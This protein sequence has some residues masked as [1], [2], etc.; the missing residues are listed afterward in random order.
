MVI[1]RLLLK[2][3]KYGKIGTDAM[4]A[5]SIEPISENSLLIHTATQIDASQLPVVIDYIEQIK[6]SFGDVILDIIPS[7]TT[8]L[9]V[10]RLTKISEET[11]IHKLK[12]LQKPLLNR[13][14][15]ITGKLIELPAF[16]HPSVAPDLLTI[17]AEKGLT[18]DEIIKIHSQK[19]YLVYAIGFAPGFAFL[20]EVET[21]IAT[22]RHTSPR[23]KVKAGSIGIAGNQTAVYPNDSPGGWKIIGNCPQALYQPNNELMTPFAIG[24]SVKFNPIN[25]A[26]FLAMG[27]QL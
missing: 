13:N 11:L 5:F 14:I 26:E 1:M 23:S 8:I 21:A 17:A 15:R 7:Y 2:R 12:N 9:V 19:N 16:Y 4:K 25:Q 20:A 18:V 6:Q 27:G 3:F 10:Y 22:P 24:D